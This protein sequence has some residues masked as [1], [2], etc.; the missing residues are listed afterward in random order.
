MKQAIYWIPCCLIAVAGCS[1]LTSQVSGIVY[2]DGKP[3]RVAEDERGTVVFRPVEGGPTTT[4]IIDRD[5]A[6]ALK[7]GS[8]DKIK[9][10]DYLVAVRVVE[11]KAAAVAGQ[12]P[13]GEPLTPA[14]Y[15]NPLESG[16]QF[17]VKSGSNQLDLELDG[18][19]GPAR[20]IEL[21]TTVEEDGQ[22]NGDGGQLAE[23]VQESPLSGDSDADSEPREGL[24]E[25]AHD[26]T[27]D[28]PRQEARP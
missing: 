15:A 12:A 3:L 4:A 21:E 7:T 6:Y 11:I 8:A 22:P 2:L 23:Q 14:I 20:A 27:T 5:G 13:S 17:T 1:D 25:G 26:G 28:G 9:P 24:D 18:N 19:A 16:L 10:G